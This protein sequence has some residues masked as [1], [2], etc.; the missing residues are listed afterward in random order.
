MQTLLKSLTKEQ[1]NNKLI[2]HSLLLRRSVVRGNFL[3]FFKLYKKAEYHSQCLIKELFNKIQ[4]QGL[5]TFCHAYRPTISIDY[6]T[7]ILG[8]ESENQCIELLKKLNSVFDDNNNPNQ[9]K[10]KESLINITK[11][12][13]SNSNLL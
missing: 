1:K 10:T 7:K 6:I 2:K 5:V 9:L 3:E 12:S 11:N 8:F 13:E 4:I